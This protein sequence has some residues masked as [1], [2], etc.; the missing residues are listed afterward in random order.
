MHQVY[1]KVKSFMTGDFFSTTKFSL[2]ATL[3]GLLTNLT[4]NKVIAVTVGPKGIAILSQF[5]N[6]INVLTSF[7]TA[8]VGNGVIKLV[9]EKREQFSGSILSTSLCL[10]LL[11]SFTISTLLFVFREIVSLTLFGNLEYERHLVL[12]SLNIPFLALNNWLIAVLNGERR[13][14]KLVGI[15]V[16][17]HMVQLFSTVLLLYFFGLNIGLLGFVTIHVIVF[18]IT[19]IFFLIQ[20][21]SQ[22]RLAL[23][24][25]G[26]LKHLLSF[27]GV[28]LVSFIAS[29][30]VETLIR[31][32][33]T[34]ELGLGGAGLWDALNKLSQSILSFFSLTMSIY[35][36]PK[37][38]S[39]IEIKRLKKELLIGLRNIIIPLFV[40]LTS[41]Y[42]VRGHIINLLFDESF[43]VLVD[44]VSL[45]FV[46]VFFK[47]VGWIL[48]YL[49]VARNWLLPY[50]ISE[51][52]VQLL[53]YFLAVNMLGFFG[54][55]G[56]VYS[57]FVVNILYVAGISVYIFKFQFSSK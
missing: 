24:R 7:S 1:F 19:S 3:A 32:S 35:L 27:S 16:A 21:S 2:I 22:L 38:S 36:L 4:L 14:K 48:G 51:I 10:V 42:I 31:S 34:G 28:A 50:V 33:I 56:L 39:I 29:P 25:F 6:L 20:Y 49:L 13:I 11:S 54:F 30:S 17:T 46:G 5:Q 55:E 15:R 44:Y 47:T 57:Y 53:Y 40:I 43:L 45:Q 18:F 9:A 41:L 37:F 52:I 23:F 26:I 12:L 8:G